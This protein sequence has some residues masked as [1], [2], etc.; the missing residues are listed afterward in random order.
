MELVVKGTYDKKNER[1]Y[2]DT[3]EATVE[4]M[5]SFLEEHDLNVF[6]AWLGY[7]EDGMSSEALAFVD[8]LQ[9]TEDEIELADGSKI[10]LVEGQ[11]KEWNNVLQRKTF[12][13]G[14][15]VY[16][17]CVGLSTRKDKEGSISVETV[18]NIGNKYVTTNKRMY[19][20]ADGVLATEYSPNY[21]LWINKDEV[22]TKVAKDKL[23]SKLS[24][25]FTKGLGGLQD[26]KLYKKLSLED[27]QEIERIIDKGDTK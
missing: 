2:V 20:L 11:E 22:E 12:F 15:E 6:E 10:K 16:A 14:Q 9:T 26:Q 3:D 7:L 27:L 1:W 4:A 23:F 8:L 17:E 13:V 18:T 5:N 24:W 19:R 25:E 21:V